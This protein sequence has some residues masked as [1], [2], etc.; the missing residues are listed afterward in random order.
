MGLPKDPKGDK[1]QIGSEPKWE[2]FQRHLIKLSVDLDEKTKSIDLLL[3]TI[4]AHQENS[5]CKTREENA[6]YRVE[7]NQTTTHL[8]ED[9]SKLLETYAHSTRK[10]KEITFELESLNEKKRRENDITKTHLLE[11]RQRISNQIQDASDEWNSGKEEREELWITKKAK[12]IR[13]RTVE[14][15]QPEIRRLSATQE[16]EKKKLLDEAIARKHHHVKQ[17]NL[18]FHRDF[19]IY[20]DEAEKRKMLLLERRL[21]K[22]ENKIFEF[23]KGHLNQLRNIKEDAANVIKENS[24]SFNEDVMK[25]NCV[26]NINN[27]DRQLQTKLNEINKIQEQKIGMMHCNFDKS[28]EKIEDKMTNLGEE[29]EK[30]KR[31]EFQSKIEEEMKVV[32]E[33]I[34]NKRD[35]DID[36]LIRSNHK[37]ETELEKD[38]F[39]RKK[40]ESTSTESNLAE[41]MNQILE[42]NNMMKNMLATTSKDVEATKIE[43]Q[44]VLEKAEIKEQLAFKAETGISVMKKAYESL[45]RTKMNPNVSMHKLIKD[46]DT[47][48][49]CL[50][51]NLHDLQNT[52]SSIELE[53]KAQI[54]KSMTKHGDELKE[55]EMTF[56]H[57][58]RDNER[59]LDCAGTDV[60]KITIKLEKKREILMT[61][62]SSQSLPAKVQPKVSS[63]HTKSRKFT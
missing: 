5:D 15:L 1:S 48:Q 17:M 21:Q 39:E 61:L 63:R 58:M 43:Q 53:K 12:H 18:E 20:F 60:K 16:V 30:N 50:K 35:T 13:S 44:N 4:K 41:K 29:W 32:T 52:L 7:F 9:L 62:Y 37:I 45:E 42:K 25:T 33:S 46:Y 55:M 54:E 23:E 57:D 19:N 3:D 8:N 10:K 11:I 28:L 59:A 31:L 49:F 27:L 56:L 2:R 6:K 36:T 34:Q 51:Q 40:Q 14:A 47:K 26:D 24:S 22:W 38:F